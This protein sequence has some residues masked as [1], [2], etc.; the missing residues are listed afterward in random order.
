[1]KNVHYLAFSVLIYPFSCCIFLF[2]INGTLGSAL[3]LKITKKYLCLRVFKFVHI[4]LL[5]KTQI[6]D[7]IIKSYDVHL[8]YH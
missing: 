5:I 8:R 6:S 7:H 1:M 3:I 4:Y 2:E